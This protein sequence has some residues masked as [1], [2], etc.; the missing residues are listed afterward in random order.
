MT[1]RLRMKMLLLCTTCHG[2]SM[3][4]AGDHRCTMTNN[5]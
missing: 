3:T 4:V 1:A 5:G 2:G